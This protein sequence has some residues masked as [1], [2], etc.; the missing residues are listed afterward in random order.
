MFKKYYFEN[1]KN[2]SVL[3]VLAILYYFVGTVPFVHDLLLDFSDDYEEIIPNKEL[4]FLTDDYF[5]LQEKVPVIKEVNYMDRLL[6]SET[7]LSKDMRRF[8]SDIASGRIKPI[9]NGRPKKSSRNEYIHG[10]V[11]YYV[12]CNLSIDESSARAAKDLGLKFGNPESI[13]KVY[14]RYEKEINNHD[15]WLNIIR[16]KGFDVGEMEGDS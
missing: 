1:Y 2:L 10:Q 11:Q 15:Y 12:D 3:E 13:K 16:K 5:L 7:Y 6:N 14:Q 8:I 4:K 9:K